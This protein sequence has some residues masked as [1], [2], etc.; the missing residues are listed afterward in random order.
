MRHFAWQLVLLGK[1]STPYGDVRSPYGCR[2]TSSSNTVLEMF[3]GYMCALEVGRDVGARSRRHPAC[4]RSCQ[5]SNPPCGAG[6]FRKGVRW[7]VCCVVLWRTQ[8]GNSRED[9]RDSCFNPATLRVGKD[10]EKSGV[11]LG[12]EEHSSRVAQLRL[13]PTPQVSSRDRASS[14]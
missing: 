3:W 7:G 13:S 10:T 5:P 14:S 1:S 8:V 2:P 9:G 4:D 6:G 12:C 11:D